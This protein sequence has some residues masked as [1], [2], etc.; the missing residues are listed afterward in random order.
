MRLAGIRAGVHPGT[1]LTVVTAGPNGT[2]SG[3][4]ATELILGQRKRPSAIVAI[5]DV[6]ALGALAA[7]G[8]HGVVVGAGG[9]SVTGFDD[10]PAAAAAN[11]TSVR[12]PVRDKGRLMGRMLLDPSFTDERVQLPT[13]LVVRSSTAPAPR[14][15]VARKSTA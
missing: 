12:Q 6:L 3:R 10:V 8:E 11:L 4:A 2:E 9:V 7:L 14:V 15:R 1:R 13:E 5:S